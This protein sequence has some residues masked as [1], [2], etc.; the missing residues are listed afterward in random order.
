M[1]KHQHSHV[2][3]SLIIP[4]NSSIPVENAAT[5]NRHSRW[6]LANGKSSSP[7]NSDMH[8]RPARRCRPTCQASE[9]YIVVMADAGDMKGKAPQWEQGQW[10]SV[11]SEAGAERPGQ[12]HRGSTQ[13]LKP[14]QGYACSA[15]TPGWLQRPSQARTGPS[16]LPLALPCLLPYVVCL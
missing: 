8:T 2:R 4:A 12:P 6:P 16:W 13:L 3:G 1:T 9:H 10:P 7:P 5:A 11:A 14:T 15:T